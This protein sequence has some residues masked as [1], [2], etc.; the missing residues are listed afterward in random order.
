MINSGTIEYEPKNLK[1]DEILIKILF[2][3]VYTITV[4]LIIDNI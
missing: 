1:Q 2:I 3:H 4:V